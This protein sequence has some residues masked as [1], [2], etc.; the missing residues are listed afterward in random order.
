MRSL[1]RLILSLLLLIGALYAKQTDD[2]LTLEL[3]ISKK[4][5]YV[6]EPIKLSYIFKYHNSLKLS[7]VSFHPPAFQGFWVKREKKS[8][9]RVEGNFTKYMINF[10]LYP[11]RSGELTIGKGVINAAL[12][13]KQKKRYYSYRHMKWKTLSTKARQ[14]EVKPLPNGLEA[15]GKYHLNVAVDRNKTAPNEPVT[16]TIRIEGVGNVDDI[17][18]FDLHI[19]ECT[20]YG[21]EPERISQLKDGEN[22][23][24]FRQKFVILCDRDYTIAPIAFRFLDSSSYSAKSLRST[25]FHIKVTGGKKEEATSPKTEK[26]TPSYKKIEARDL[27]FTLLGVMVG[28]GLMFL[29]LKRRADP[30]AK[31]LSIREKIRKSKSERELLHVL[32]PYLGV[33]CRLDQI[34]KVL[35]ANI[36]EG[37]KHP[38]D[39]K[40][41]AREFDQL[42]EDEKEL[43][44]LK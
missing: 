26:A 39:K 25:P 29:L 40:R 38:I 2:N 41:L 21:E 35:E 11:Q 24:L 23:A 37:A 44:I 22:I 20:V 34:I 5:A 17:E 12:L 4:S 43:E 10:I 3:N 36:F 1:G 8:P 9:T 32:L 14:I 18:K 7:R 27:L 15:F 33:S 13:T 42:I 16:L 19:P 30:K 28:M 31:A 6:G